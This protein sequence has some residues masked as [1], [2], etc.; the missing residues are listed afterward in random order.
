MKHLYFWN[1]CRWKHIRL[2]AQVWIA[3]NNMFMTLKLNCNDGGKAMKTRIIT[4]VAFAASVFFCACQKETAPASSE[5][6][7]TFTVSLDEVSKTTLGSDGKVLWEDGDEISINGKIY[8]TA[9]GGSTTAIFTAVS[10]DA[11]ANVEGKAYKAFYPV[12][13]ANMEM[14]KVQVNE[15]I[16]N[17]PMYAES[18]GTTLSF[19]N[20]CGIIE[21]KIKGEK[22]VKNILLTSSNM[23]FSG[24]YTLQKDDGGNMAAATGTSKNG[25]VLD[26]GEGV[27]LTTDGTVLRIAAPAGIYQKLKILI[28]ATDESTC[29]IK[30]ANDITVTRSHI[31]PVVINASTFA[32]LELSGVFTVNASGKKVKFSRG[33]MYWEGLQDKFCVEPNQYFSIPAELD[34]ASGNSWAG[35]Q[36]GMHLSF[37]PW[38]SNAANAKTKYYYAPA[39]ANEIHFAYNGGAIEGWTILSADEWEYLMTKRTVNGGT[40]KDKAFRGNKD[41]RIK[42]SG[43]DFSGIFIYPDNYTGAYNEDTWDKVHAAGI[44]YLPACGTYGSNNSVNGNG[45][46]SGLKGRFMYQSPTITKSD[47]YYSKTLY[48]D[49]TNMTFVDKDAGNGCSIRLVKVVQE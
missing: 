28:T 42:V 35:Y 7:L 32:P 6:G 44:V 46:V 12:S 29:E 40:G 33:L 24:K 8:R 10:G 1:W 31:K 13:A 43:S 14:P 48:Y 26:C 37:F 4:L 3:L 18:D 41:K 23:T 15:G 27:A 19:T 17:A 36:G 39:S 25:V 47:K 34:G 16:S 45:Y 38:T 9:K 11:V 49:G 2:F 22:V 21:L 30:S 5:T 20:L